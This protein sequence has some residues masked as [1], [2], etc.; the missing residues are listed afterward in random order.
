MEATHR[1]LT[2]GIGAG[3]HATVV[4]VLERMSNHAERFLVSGGQRQCPGT[5]DQD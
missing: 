5:F 4:N 2:A 3:E 1:E